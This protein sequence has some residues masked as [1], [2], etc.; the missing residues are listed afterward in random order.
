MWHHLPTLSEYNWLIVNMIHKHKQI[1]AIDGA[2]KRVNSLQVEHIKKSLS[3]QLF[4]AK[5]FAN[6]FQNNPI[7]KVTRNKKSWET[8]L[9]FFV[10]SS[11]QSQWLYCDFIVKHKFGRVDLKILSIM[12]FIL[13]VVILKIWNFILHFN[14]IDFN[15]FPALTMNICFNF[16]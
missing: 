3:I 13:A 7:V 16:L 6:C 12:C 5:L 1:K 10:I 9:L 2:R 14:S 15:V 11:F 8:I 4:G